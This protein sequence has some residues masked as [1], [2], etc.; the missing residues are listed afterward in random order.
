MS[1]VCVRARVCTHIY[2]EQGIQNNSL[3]NNYLKKDVLDKLIQP[4]NQ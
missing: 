3:L 4:L 1:C 2:S